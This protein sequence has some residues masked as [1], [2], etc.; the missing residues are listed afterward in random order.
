MW[1]VRSIYGLPT[2]NIFCSQSAEA[3][4]RGTN[5]SSDGHTAKVT[6]LREKST[7]RERLDHGFRL[8]HA[9]SEVNAVDGQ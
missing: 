9:G 1:F 2:K 3:I 4:R 6:E 7:Y 8:T 5:V